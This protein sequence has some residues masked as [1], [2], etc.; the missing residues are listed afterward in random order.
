M[1]HSQTAL[2]P[3]VVCLCLF[4]W[5]GIHSVSQKEIPDVFV[6]MSHIIFLALVLLSSNMS[7]VQQ[8]FVVDLLPQDWARS[9]LLDLLRRLRRTSL[10]WKE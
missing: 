2:Q 1:Q 6:H 9:E 8:E 5:Y 3:L 7:K 10:I 4:G